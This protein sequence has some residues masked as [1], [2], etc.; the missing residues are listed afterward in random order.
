MTSAKTCPE[1]ILYTIP[2]NDFQTLVKPYS[3]NIVAIIFHLNFHHDSLLVK[4]A[5][6]YGPLFEMLIFS[7][8]IVVNFTPFHCFLPT[9]L[10]TICILSKVYRFCVINLSPN[11]ITFQPLGSKDLSETR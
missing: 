6:T 1:I 4:K 2:H 7:V 9:V 8:I 11:Q 3:I 5:T 10:F